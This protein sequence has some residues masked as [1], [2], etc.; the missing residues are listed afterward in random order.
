M[1]DIIFR[2]KDKNLKA[3][4]TATVKIEDKTETYSQQILFV[5]LNGTY[6]IDKILLDR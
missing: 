4:A 3:D 1:V 2:V 6:Y 5:K